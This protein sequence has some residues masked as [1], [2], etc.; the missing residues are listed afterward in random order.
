MPQGRSG[1]ASPDS[2]TNDVC[3][4]VAIIVALS[5][6]TLVLQDAARERVL[7]LKG[8]DRLVDVYEHGVDVALDLDQAPPRQSRRS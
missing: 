5:R 4:A 3:D 2:R 8:F 1:V 7:E 6:G